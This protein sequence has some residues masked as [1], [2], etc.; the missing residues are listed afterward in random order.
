VEAIRGVIRNA[1]TSAAEVLESIRRVEAVAGSI[2]TAVAEQGH[3][4]GE[5]AQRVAGVATTAQ[6]I[7]GA[8]ERLAHD[9]DSGM[10]VSHDVEGAAT[11]VTNVAGTLSDEV[12]QFLAAMRGATGTRRA[13]ERVPGNDLQVTICAAGA[14]YAAVV[15]DLSLGGVALRASLGGSRAGADVAVEVPGLGRPLQGRIA[16][17]D[18]TSVVIAFR[19][20][21]ETLELAE[22]LIARVAAAPAAC[23]A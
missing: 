2:A 11:A 13:Y 15:Q 21:A 23:A 10:H 12:D 6:A 5:I 14:R 22:A 4:T 7:S 8:M 19:Q 20:N 18:P 16:R 17:L 1:A 9:A 3:A